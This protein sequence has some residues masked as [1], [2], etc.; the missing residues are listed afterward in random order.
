ME[1]LVTGGAGY[2]GSHMVKYLQEQGHEVAIIDDLSTGHKFLFENCEFINL[3]LT[4]KIDLNTSLKN[5]K[6]SAVFHFAGKSIVRESFSNPDYYYLNNVIATK[7][8]ISCM[9]ENNLDNLIYSSSA[10]IFGNQTSKAIN[11]NFPKIPI[12]P[13]GKSKFE[14][15]NMIKQFCHNKNLNSISLRYFNAAGAH[16]SGK[17]GEFHKNETHLIPSIFNSVLNKKEITIFGNNYNTPDG[18]CVRDYIHV[19]DLVKAHLKGYEKLTKIGGYDEYN[20]GNERGYSVMDVISECENVINEKI[21]YTIK[22]RRSGDP[23]TL[24]SD[25]TKAISQ[26]NW[27]IKKSS[28]QDILKSAWNWH[29][30]LHTITA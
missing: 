22:N 26:L 12:N 19:M 21:K 8:L 23:D 6:F 25:S 29:K 18:T 20:L 13:Y 4:N 5:R 7:N 27:N 3:D 15:E 2:I 9:I 1:F 24:I 10:A 11:E 30:Y 28:L 17:I 16:H 14:C